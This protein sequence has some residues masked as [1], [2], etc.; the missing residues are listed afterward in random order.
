MT[1]RLPYST[2]EFIPPW[3]DP[4]EWRAVNDAM[5][6]TLGN[7]ASRFGPA[8]SVANAIL[9]RVRHL[10]RFLDALCADTCATCGDNCCRRA[11]VWY[12][13]KDLLGFHLGGAPIPVRQLALSPERACRFLTSSGCTMPRTQRPFVCN[14]FICA[15]QKREMAAWPLSHRTFLINSLF[16]LKV[17]RNRMEKHFMSCF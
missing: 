17:G 8:R 9:S 11:T 5:A 12:D 4:S 3:S 16:A 1:R 7:R 10:D 6:A 15:A 2:A 13:F 14:W